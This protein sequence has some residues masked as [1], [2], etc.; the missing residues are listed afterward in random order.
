MLNIHRDFPIFRKK[1][2]ENV[3][4]V[5]LD[6]AATAQK[7]KCVIDALQH[8]YSERYGTV[9][10]AVYTLAR[11]ATESYL[12]TRERVRAFIRADFS[13]EIVFTKGTTEAINLVATS[14]GRAFLR[15][16]DEILIS[17]LEHHSN[18]VPWQMAAERYGAI[19]KV[20]PIDA[21]G[22]LIFEE[23]EKLLTERT[24]IVSVAHVSNALG[25]ILP[26]KEIV[27]SAHAVG[28]K[29][30]VDGAQAIAH[31]PV[32]V[33]ELDVDFYA[34]SGHKAYGPTGIGILY[35]KRELLER[36]PP[37]QGGGDMI[38]EVS[39]TRTTYQ[40]P[41]LRFEAGTPMIAEVIALKEAIAYIEALHR[42]GIGRYEDQLVKAAIEKL[43][44]FPD[45]TL[46]GTSKNRGPILTFA[47]QN[48]HPLDLGSFLDLKGICVRT[49]HLCAQ[50]ALKHFGLKTA[51]R[52][53]F[54][55]YNT[56][57]EI[58]YFAQALE[59][60]IEKIKN[61]GVLHLGF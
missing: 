60:A 56:L 58:D 16:G 3:P 45:I 13:D 2:R 26:I 9:H 23:F 38:R 18:I 41:P 51:T 44:S 28:A 34:F 55:P 48:V 53:S 20:A 49:G 17:E 37:Y 10:R 61:P 25:T 8:F 22:D 43:S 50:P 19:L 57:E 6:S 35:G 36:M 54:A 29:V 11:D 39:F 32:D 14:F 24:K 40:D 27:R 12:E 42:Q 33:R 1:T 21:C 5:Y 59:E 31:M 30:F 52:I 15:P 47:V 4:F 7:P 46:I